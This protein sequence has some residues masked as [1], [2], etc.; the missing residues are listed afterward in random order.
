M[1]TDA[2]S[3]Y[4]FRPQHADAFYC[5][6]GSSSS[7][8][9]QFVLNNQVLRMISQFWT[10]AGRKKLN[11]RAYADLQPVEEY[12]FNDAKVDSTN[13]FHRFPS[14][15]EAFQGTAPASYTKFRLQ[16]CLQR[17]LHPNVPCP[18]NI[19]LPSQRV[20]KETRAKIF[21]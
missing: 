16:W 7:G 8:S 14:P 21:S 2:A 5:L 15:A 13:G 3:L 10:P 6:L 20:S 18:E 9:K 1:S 11:A 4:G 19:P 12:L 17:R